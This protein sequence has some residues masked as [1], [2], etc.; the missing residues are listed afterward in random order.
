[1]WLV[2]KTHIA[3]Y[4]GQCRPD[5]KEIS[6]AIRLLIAHKNPREVF[7]QQK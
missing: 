5:F 2:I 1:M 4:P 7:L 6:L 3:D